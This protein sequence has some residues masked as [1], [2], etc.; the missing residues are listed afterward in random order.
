VAGGGAAFVR[1]HLGSLNA[2][3]DGGCTFM[4]AL[5]EIEDGRSGRWD[6]W[7]V[8]D[9][10]RSAVEAERRGCCFAWGERM[11]EGTV[12]PNRF[13]EMEI[14]NVANA[15]KNASLGGIKRENMGG[16]SG[17]GG[18]KPIRGG[19]GD[20]SDDG[21]GG[22]VTGAS[23]KAKGKK[24]RLVIDDDTDDT[25]S[26]ASQ[27]DSIRR[28]SSYEQKTPRKI[29]KN[30]INTAK[31]IM[32]DDPAN[33]L[34][35][36]SPPLTQDRPQL[37]TLKIQNMSTSLRTLS[38]FF[39]PKATEQDMST[40]TSV[41]YRKFSVPD[42][43]IQSFMEEVITNSDVLN[44]EM[45]LLVVEAIG[46]SSP[47]FMK[48][49]F[50]NSKKEN[51]SNGQQPLLGG[52]VV[53]KKWLCFV[54]QRLEDQFQHGRDNNSINKDV[55][56]EEPRRIEESIASS[57][58]DLI[59]KFSV[60]KDLKQIAILKSKFRVDWFTIAEK[61]LI[62]GSAYQLSALIESSKKACDHLTVIKQSSGSSVT[63]SPSSLDRKDCT[64]SSGGGDAVAHSSS[65]PLDN[66][67]D[68]SVSKPNRREV[69]N[70][71]PPKG[72]TSTTPS[73]PSSPHDSTY[74]HDHHAKDAKSWIPPQTDQ[75]NTSSNSHNKPPSKWIP[76]KNASNVSTA[77][78]SSDSGKEMTRQQR[79]ARILEDAKRK[80]YPV[81]H[82]PQ[83]EQQQSLTSDKNNHPQKKSSIDHPRSSSSGTGGTGGHGSWADAP[84]SSTA[85]NSGVSTSGGR[86]AST[87][88]WGAPS[89]NNSTGW[90]ADKNVSSNSGNSGNSGWGDAGGGSSGW[91]KAEPNNSNSKSG[92]SGN[93]GNN[94][95]SNSSANIDH[96]SSKD[97]QK[98]GTTS[99]SRSDDFGSNGGVASSN[100]RR[101]DRMNGPVDNLS[102]DGEI[103]DPQSQSMHLKR[104]DDGG[105]NGSKRQ[106]PF[107][108][109][110]LEDSSPYPNK[111]PCYDNS[112][113]SR[114][115]SEG[116][117]N[118]NSHGRIV[119]RSSSM[120]LPGNMGRGRGRDKTIPAWMSRMQSAA[121]D[122]GNVRGTATLMAEEKATSRNS[123]ESYNSLGNESGPKAGTG[124]I[125]NGGGRG[126]DRTTPAW[127]TQKQPSNANSFVAEGGTKRRRD[128]EESRTDGSERGVSSGS[129][130][131]SVGSGRGRERT[132]PS[133]M[134]N[135]S[136]NIDV[137]G[138][139]SSDRQRDR[140]VAGNTSG[141]T[142]ARITRTPSQNA[143]IG[144]TR[145]IV[146]SDL[147]NASTPTGRGRGRTTPAWMT[148]MNI[149]TRRESKHQNEDGEVRNDAQN[150]ASTGT[151]PVGRGRGRDMTKP[152]WMT[153]KTNNLDYGSGTDKQDNGAMDKPSRQHTD[154]EPVDPQN[155][156]RGR[157]RTTPAW[158]A[159]KSSSVGH[160]SQERQHGNADNSSIDR[161]DNTRPTE[162]GTVVSH[163]ATG[164]RSIG[165]A[166]IGRG[167]ALTTPAWMTKKSTDADHGSA[168]NNSHSRSPS[169][170]DI[171]QPRL[172]SVE[173]SGGRSNASRGRDR[174]RERVNHEN[175]DPG[176]GNQDYSK[177]GRSSSMGR[178]RDQTLPAWMTA[179]GGPS[180]PLKSKSEGDRPDSNARDNHDFLKSKSEGDRPDSNARDNH[181]FLKSKSE[182]DRPDSNARDNHDFQD[183]SDSRTAPSSRSYSDQRSNSRHQSGNNNVDVNT[184]QNRN[185]ELDDM[186]RGY[187]DHRDRGDNRDHRDRGDNRDHR[188][189]GDNRDHRD[190][191]G[192]R[193][194]RDHRDHRD[195]RD[196]E[197]H[198]SHI[199]SDRSSR[200]LGRGRDVNRPAWMTKN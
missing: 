178:G 107:R 164:E 175:V 22:L 82:L 70:W 19:G 5:R 159:Q 35:I 56:S 188:D 6:E 123:R 87:G 1:R 105:D 195:R 154:T 151:N 23:R 120:P 25:D 98:R 108:Y 122:G 2:N 180:T 71:I 100:N 133:W 44:L 171:V 46:R 34:N 126:R 179:D 112:S 103:N 40:T 14:E 184:T 198:S 15:K 61:S 12:R 196:R 80:H 58:L 9:Y 177:A 134:T 39:E 28:P 128:N 160:S 92:W 67:N 99:N 153:K 48:A 131:G 65:S 185:G 150:N 72:V 30:R 146:S 161:R 26:E 74:H 16:I 142:S 66:R 68:I 51:S 64:M 192:D 29:P 156:G 138:S 11:K 129:V 106:A 143:D 124:G 147:L 187:R 182:G 176:R 145:R 37:S 20:G 7:S 77:T 53:F 83:K 193:D 18:G 157:G 90:G 78:N 36:T 102:E 95:V 117:N 76:P 173:G 165:A 141:I 166:G 149:D 75:S 189:R 168:D 27:K 73:S 127:M 130:G 155:T 42:D 114:A 93:E 63:E 41:D 10:V 54:I 125:E 174:E 172:A 45:M 109:R 148:Q 84:S 132:M 137:V 43:R 31:V 59:C 24:N 136:S 79:M 197:T 110:D 55:G 21:E 119:N 194:H 52:Y 170:R 32:G 4:M 139:T 181:D 69:K 89:V 97:E 191:G 88:G 38:R 49:M 167:R 33:D 113:K 190:H 57:I 94:T 47:K 85:G 116:N 50:R 115:V 8:E 17:I 163:V 60:I 140:D 91:N 199:S 135:K 152:A 104:N 3:L 62:F 81:P 158:M 162:R 101:S 96:R 169:M 200:G 183:Q 121:A 118:S 13:L 144:S 86:N 186:G 111:K